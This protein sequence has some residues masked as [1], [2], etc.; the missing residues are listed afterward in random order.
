MSG[1]RMF[2]ADQGRP[3]GLSRPGPGWVWTPAPPGTARYRTV[4]TELQ[5]GRP[6]KNAPLQ[7]LHTYI[8]KR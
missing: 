6:A 3:A 8:A 1:S 5:T 7:G 4:P 2:A